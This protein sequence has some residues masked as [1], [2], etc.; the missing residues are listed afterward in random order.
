MIEQTKKQKYIGM[1]KAVKSD[2]SMAESAIKFIESYDGNNTDDFEALVANVITTLLE[3]EDA[4]IRAEGY[5]KLMEIRGDFQKQM[6]V[7]KSGYR[8]IEAGKLPTAP[9]VSANL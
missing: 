5:D 6:N 3:F 2:A 8:D 7:L 1:I 4:K 9:P